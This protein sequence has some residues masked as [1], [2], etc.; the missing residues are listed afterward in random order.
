MSNDIMIYGDQNINL[1]DD[2]NKQKLQ[3]RLKELLSLNNV[4]FL[5]GNGASLLLG[6]PRI[7]SVRKLLPEIEK[8]ETDVNNDEL[9]HFLTELLD[10]YPK[11]N[12]DHDTDLETLLSGLFNF[13]SIFQSTGEYNL[14]FNKVKIKKD[15]V[16]KLVF[17]F[18][19]FLFDKCEN[20]PT[21]HPKFLQEPFEVHKNFFRKLLLRPASLPRVKV[22]T[23]NYDLIIEKSLD[24]LGVSYFDGFSG[25][26]DR[27]IQTETYNYD[28]YF[29]GETIEGKVKRVDRV[30]HLLKLHGSINWIKVRSS[31][32]NVWGIQQ[33]IPKKDQFGDLMIY[34][35]PIKEGEILGYPYSEM[36]RHFSYSINRPQSVL[37]TI[38][39]SFN[40]RHI[41]RLIYQCFSIPSFTL[42]III[43]NIPN[44]ENNELHRLVNKVKNQRIIVISGAIK[45]NSEYVG[46]A[47]TFQGFTNDWM[48]DIQELDIEKKIRGELDKL[49][50]EET[51]VE[52]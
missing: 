49:F 19:K 29:P 20:L 7:S 37:F 42:V 14:T 22:F 24:S 21:I 34:P 5:I 15:F 45:K 18:K 26:V 31:S 32:N 33:G 39:Y 36:F 50:N 27:S 12:G 28:L 4:S 2:K 48:P 41:N 16:T 3:L 52:E 9:I 40:D 46:G 6:A 43:P 25:T 23:I 1:N 17:L 13:E 44:E 8:V 51:D 11:S 35:S 38:G 47:G 30:L 10:L